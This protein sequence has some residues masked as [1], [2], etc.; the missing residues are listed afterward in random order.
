M[1][2]ID[3]Y[4]YI[5]QP[6]GDT[7]DTSSLSISTESTTFHP[8]LGTVQDSTEDDNMLITGDFNCLNPL[9]P[10]VQQ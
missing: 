5:E 2:P 6:V 8:R 10:S 4:T 9:L 1:L 3:N 7:T